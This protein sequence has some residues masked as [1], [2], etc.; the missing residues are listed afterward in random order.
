MKMSN[1][2]A[3]FFQASLFPIIETFSKIYVF[4][5]IVVETSLQQINQRFLTFNMKIEKKKIILAM[6]SKNSLNIKMKQFEK[7][8]YN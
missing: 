6:F 4:F 1:F 8:F 2:K 7:Y 5:F 3:S